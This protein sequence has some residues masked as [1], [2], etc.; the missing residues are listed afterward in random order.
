MSSSDHR[1][2]LQECRERGCRVERVKSGYYKIWLPDGRRFVRVSA[3]P[4][5]QNWLNRVRADFRRLCLDL[6]LRQ[7]ETGEHG[8]GD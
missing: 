5:S 6:S 4:S 2:L 7:E 8:G 1:K 3:T